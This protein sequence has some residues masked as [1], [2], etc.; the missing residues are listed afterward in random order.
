MS[1]E[2][3]TLVER[4]GGSPA[5]MMAEV[6]IRLKAAINEVREE[7]KKANHQRV[8]DARKV[9]APRTV[10]IRAEG[11]APGSGFLP[12]VFDIKGPDQ[13]NIWHVRRLVVGGLTPT[14]V[15]AGRIDVFVSAAD[16]SRVNSLAQI[17]LADWADQ[18][19][20]LPLVGSYGRGELTLRHNEKLWLFL[21][22][23]TPAQ[24]Y[25]AAASVENFQEASVLQG[26]GL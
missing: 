5:G 11:T 13:G 10:L 7:I 22:N 18:A 23:G 6:G 16:L 3:Q 26:W 17:G 4:N 20:A 14:T 21:S 15:A 12:L 24:D 25:V 9:E 2:Y 1:D 19:T 8:E